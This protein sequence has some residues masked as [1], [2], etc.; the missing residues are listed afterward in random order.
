MS[1]A[2]AFVLSTLPPESRK[3]L[4]FS[5]PD[6]TRFLQGLVSADL[7]RL[8]EHNSVAASLLT[9]KAKLLSDALIWRQ[10]E[11]YFAAFPA[12][13][14]DDMHERLE[15]HIIMDDVQCQR[16]D[17][18]EIVLN[19]AAPITLESAHTRAEWML[20]DCSYPLAGQIWVGPQAHLSDLAQHL[21]LE[22]S[23]RDFDRL[24][25][26]QGLPAWGR[27]LDQ[28]RMPPEAGFIDSVSFSKGCFMGQEPL[29]RIHARGKVNWVMLRV[30]LQDQSGNAQRPE[31]GSEGGPEATT[32]SIASLLPLELSAPAREKAG[33]LRSFCEGQGLAIVHRREAT[34]NN[35]LEGQGYSFAVISKPLGDDEGLA[36]KA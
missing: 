1:K 3:I 20:R 36:S 18:L 29:A 26:A 8:D 27:E 24:R 19:C 7:R 23:Q 21:D 25:I 33:T 16:R 28:D 2:R 35:R 5:G 12:S 4:S 17:D 10:G 30:E 15:K 13:R 6:A 9:V 31:G 14:F 34:L 22:G 11:L 32:E